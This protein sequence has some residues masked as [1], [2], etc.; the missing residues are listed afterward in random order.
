MKE[1]K[2]SLTPIICEIC[3]T[4]QG[5][6]RFRKNRKNE[7]KIRYR[8]QCAG[9]TSKQ[10]NK[11]NPD[12]RKIIQQR[13]R[14]RYRE[15]YKNYKYQ[16]MLHIGQ[17]CCKHCNN[18]DTRVLTFHHR[19]PDEKAFKVSWGFTH[20]LTMPKLKAEAEKCDVLCANC[21][22]IAHTNDNANPNAQHLKCKKALLE[23]IRQLCCSHCG[24]DDIRVLTFHHNDPETKEFKLSTQGRSMEEMKAEAEKCTVLCD[25]C[26]RI[27]HAVAKESHSANSLHQPDEQ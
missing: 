10:W 14:R 16:L 1:Q 7:V 23:H 22:I 6:I 18:P 27:L 26:H 2:E 21:H 20:S 8:R 17:T 11:D 12:K 3:K 25:N 15:E 13:A 9:C 5:Q 19:N 24:S 4:R